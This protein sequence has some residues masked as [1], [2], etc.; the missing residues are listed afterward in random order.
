M[1][2]YR[3]THIYAEMSL[4][5]TDRYRRTTLLAYLLGGAGLVR[6]GLGRVERLLMYR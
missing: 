5:D 2:W 1:R 4:G 6:W 3:P